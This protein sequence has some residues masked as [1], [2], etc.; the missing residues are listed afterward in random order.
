MQLNVEQLNEKIRES[1]FE[2]TRNVGGLVFQHLIPDGPQAVIPESIFRDYFL[3]RF[4]GAVQDSRADWVLK[5]ISV[6]GSPVAEVGVID[7][8]TKQQLFVVPPLLYTNNL[9]LDRKEGDLGDIF[10]RYKQITN[11][12]PQGG[13]KFLFEALHYK[14]Q[15]YLSSLNISPAEAQWYSIMIR[16]GLIQEDQVTGSGEPSVEDMFDFD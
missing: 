10:S 1:I 14:N 8:I 2:E 6:A 4:V 7:D 15:E 9:G 16:Y 11:N 5:W 13:T 3:P 12:L